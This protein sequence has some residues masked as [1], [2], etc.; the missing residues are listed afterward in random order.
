MINF[1]KTVIHDSKAFGAAIKAAR[2]GRKESRRN[3]VRTDP[4]GNIKPDKKKSTE[5]IDGAVAAATAL[6][7]AVRN[8]R[9]MGSVYDEKGFCAFSL[10]GLRG[11]KNL[12]VY[13]VDSHTMVY[14]KLCMSSGKHI[15]VRWNEC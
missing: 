6:D 8:G 4:A 10:M 5:K 9:S 13:G 7:R 1:S 11:F 14:S 15:Y 3:F 12:F 2:T